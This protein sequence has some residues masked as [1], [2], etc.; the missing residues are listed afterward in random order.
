MPRYFL[1]VTYSDQRVIGDPRG[2]L[3]RDDANAIQV[4]RR[5]IDD[6]QEERLLGEPQPSI[7]VMNE[8]GEVIYR[9]PSN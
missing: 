7:V 5:I 2:T 8:A 3:L 9:F 1:T 4:A 6:L